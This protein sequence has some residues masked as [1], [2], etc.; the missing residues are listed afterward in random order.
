VA[1]RPGDESRAI[2]EI[3]ALQRFLNQLTEL[4]R[5]LVATL[6]EIG[7]RPTTVAVKDS[8]KIVSVCALARVPEVIESSP[9]VRPD[10]RPFDYKRGR[11]RR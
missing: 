8:T 3:Q 6:V 11:A 10:P 9:V 2:E 1:D 4:N 5:H 7:T